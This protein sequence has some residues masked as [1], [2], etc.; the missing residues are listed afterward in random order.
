[1]PNPFTRLLGG[2]VAVAER[3]AAQTLVS[4]TDLGDPSWTRRSFAALAQEGFARN[5]VVHRCVRLIAESGQPRAAGAVEDGQAA[6]A[7]IRC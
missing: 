7:T 1:M 3:K 6:R 5:P 2:R 4:W